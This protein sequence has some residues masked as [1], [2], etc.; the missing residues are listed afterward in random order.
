MRKVA[1]F[2]DSL[3]L[4]YPRISQLERVFS[5]IEKPLSGCFGPV[6]FLDWSGVDLSS[7]PL[8]SKLL[9]V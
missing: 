3:I 8:Q 5:N 1:N 6:I 2:D 9:V 7:N 4:V